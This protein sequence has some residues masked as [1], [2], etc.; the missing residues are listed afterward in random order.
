MGFLDLWLRHGILDQQV[1]FKLTG[2]L[3]IFIGF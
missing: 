2:Y 3:K 1:L